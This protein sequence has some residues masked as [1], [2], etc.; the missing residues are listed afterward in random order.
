[1]IHRDPNLSENGYGRMERIVEI[2]SLPNVRQV[3]TR[4]RNPLV[5]LLFS[6]SIPLS[7]LYKFLKVPFKFPLS[8]L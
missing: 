7:V 2:A 6:F 4:K 8:S 5:F 3:I 1:M